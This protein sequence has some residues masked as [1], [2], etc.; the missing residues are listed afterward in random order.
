MHFKLKIYLAYCPSGN[1]THF[2]DERVQSNC[3]FSIWYQ[4]T[5]LK[6][7]FIRTNVIYTS[8][9]EINSGGQ[10]H[11][12]EKKCNT[13]HHKGNCTQSEICHSS[14]VQGTKVF[15]KSATF[16]DR[17]L[18]RL[19]YIDIT[20]KNT[21]VVSVMVMETMATLFLKFQYLMF[22]LSVGDMKTPI[23]Q[24]SSY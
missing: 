6:Y 24:E 23:K 2:T 22:N 17:K 5:Q 21:D 11:K 12:S 20:K 3:I 19:N 15:E 14:T 16:R 18:L 8:S 4:Y 1:Y 10:I 13:K 7:T 9:S